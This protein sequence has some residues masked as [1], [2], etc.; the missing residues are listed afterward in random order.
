MLHAISQDWQPPRVA[1]SCNKLLRERAIA[2]GHAVEVSTLHTYNSHLQLYL[3]FCKLHH[4]PIEP[5][6]DTLSFFV[7]FMSHHIQ[8]ASISAYLSGICNGL[9]PYFPAVCAAHTS[10]IMSR[11]LAGMCKLCGA[12]TPCQKCTLSDDDLNSLLTY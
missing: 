9:E 7:V 5:T 2:L 4:F 8:P 1:W 6:P 10:S 11:S 3:S 12:S